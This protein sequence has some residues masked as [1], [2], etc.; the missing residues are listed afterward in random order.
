MHFIQLLF[1]PHNTPELHILMIRFVINLLFMS[2]LMG[3]Y[4]RVNKNSQYLFNFIVFNILIFFVSSFL[5]RINLETGFAFGLFA[6]F[7]ILRYRTEAIPIKEMT[8]MFTA[9]IMATINSTV[10]LNL[11]YWEVLFANGVILLTVFLLERKWLM[12]YKPSKEILFEQIELIHEDRREELIRVLEER[13]GYSI[14]SIKV[15]KIDFLRDTAKL[16]VYMG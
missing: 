4:Y 15:N 6:I 16:T 12:N 14:S 7:S 10:T 2:L 9:I 5:S 1:A 13:T 3:T 8:F 11:N